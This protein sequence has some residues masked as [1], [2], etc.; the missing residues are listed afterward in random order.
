MIPRPGSLPYPA[1]A[2]PDSRPPPPHPASRLSQL[3]LVHIRRRQPQLENTPASLARMVRE[4]AVLLPRQRPRDGQPDPR[5]PP[6]RDRTFRPVE[7]IEHPLSLALRDARPPVR[8][9]EHE[10]PPVA[11]RAELDRRTVGREA[12]RVLDQVHENAQR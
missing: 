3:P 4:P 12:Q 5:P 2:F 8:N 11:L 6:V 9:R 10:I 7:R 1:S